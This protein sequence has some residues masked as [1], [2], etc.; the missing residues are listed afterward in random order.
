MILIKVEVRL[1]D[2]HVFSLTMKKYLP[3]V[4]VVLLWIHNLCWDNFFPR[5][6]K[7]IFDHIINQVVEI[8]KIVF[9]ANS[10]SG[11]SDRFKRALKL[12]YFAGAN[13]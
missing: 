1:A 2:L 13:Y 4:T 12:A 7:S 11:R 10:N 5:S 6:P 8:H 3:L 9:I